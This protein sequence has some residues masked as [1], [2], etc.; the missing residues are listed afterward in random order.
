MNRTIVYTLL[1][2]CLVGLTSAGIS[3]LK[4]KP[5]E[6]I[7]VRDNDTD[8]LVSER[9]LVAA[10][11]Y[12]LLIPDSI[13]SQENDTLTWY[14]RKQDITGLKYQSFELNEPVREYTFRDT[15]YYDVRA[16][17]DLKE[18]GHSLMH[19]IDGDRLNVQWGNELEQPLGATF[20]LRDASTNVDR[21]SWTINRAGTGEEAG[22]GSDVNL[23]WTPS[24]TGTYIAAIKVEFKSGKVERSQ[25]TLAVIP[26]PPPPKPEPKKAE[27]AP[28]K[29]KPEKW[30]PP[31]YEP[32]APVASSDCFPRSVKTEGTAFLVPVER[33]TRNQVEFLDQATSFIVSPIH[34]CMFTGFD[35]FATGKID[36][37]EITI[38][39]LSNCT[40][41]RSITIK[42]K[43]AHDAYEAVKASFTSLPIM[44]ADYRYKITVKAVSPGQLGFF[45]TKGNQFREE[46]NGRAIRDSNI[47]LTMLDEKTCIYNLRFVR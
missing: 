11:D 9:T 20:S 8:S 40:G 24:D 17:L 7:R 37:I 13:L 46:R 3:W 19:V 33:P 22:S 44:N 2:F 28:V 27:P 34:D 26:A 21:R 15:G 12:D 29:P 31:A 41:K 32:P 16:Y 35:Y 38:E 39:C 42:T 18:V 6:P 1:A 25:E 36:N 14:I 43:G 45:Q 47:T 4:T 23:D 10:H 5:P 30:T